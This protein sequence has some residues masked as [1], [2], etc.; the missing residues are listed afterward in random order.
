M[1][2]S[3]WVKR[4]VWNRRV[5]L[6]PAYS[7]LMVWQLMAW[8]WQGPEAMHTAAVTVSTIA[9]V[10]M[11]L[12]FSEIFGREGSALRM[13]PFRSKTLGTLLWTEAVLL[14]PVWTLMTLVGYQALAVFV[15][16]LGR[17]PWATQFAAPVSGLLWAGVALAP[18]VLGGVSN[19]GAKRRQGARPYLDFVESLISFVHVPLLGMFV[20]FKL[21][22]LNEELRGLYLWAHVPMAAA[23]AYTWFRR[24]ALAHFPANTDSETERVSIGA[25]GSK[26]RGVSVLA[27][28][29]ALGV[30]VPSRWFWV[31]M[32]IVVL[33]PWMN[34]DGA[35]R[36]APMLSVLAAPVASGVF[37]RMGGSLRALRALPMSTGRMTFL[38]ARRYYVEIAAMTVVVEGACTVSWGVFSWPLL[39]LMGAVA[40]L[41][42]CLTVAQLTGD[43]SLAPFAS[44]VGGVALLIAAVL[45]GGPYGIGIRADLTTRILWV[46]G[47]LAVLLNPLGLYLLWRTIGQSSDLYCA[48]S[49]VLSQRAEEARLWPSGEPRSFHLFR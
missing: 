18:S 6:L 7:A 31:V 9:S 41:T 43:L 10:L 25:W 45:L 39:A 37:L 29:R 19:P 36:Y 27:R 34:L 3:R 14:V 44:A 32:P 13:L 11:A 48:N 35:V 5:V 26:R 30:A 4:R 2:L 21:G 47:P 8:R 12:L 1:M 22:T 28:L 15:P 24:E 33:T 42:L 49:D 16:S 17:M 20:L 38:V 46:H 40:G 23:L